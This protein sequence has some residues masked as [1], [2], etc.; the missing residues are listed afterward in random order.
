MIVVIGAGGDGH[1]DLH[2]HRGVPVSERPDP[3]PGPGFR[4]PAR[5]GPAEDN[6]PRV[7][8]DDLET[9]RLSRPVPGRGGPVT[10][11]A[12]GA[13]LTA[14]ARAAPARSPQSDA[15]RS[16]LPGRDCR[17]RAAEIST[18]PPHRSCRSKKP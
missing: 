16:A 9:E 7:P 13:G 17:G 1:G 2:V 14:G 18:A 10:L 4:A 15:S 8:G 12:D 11:A 3:G 5:P 6:A